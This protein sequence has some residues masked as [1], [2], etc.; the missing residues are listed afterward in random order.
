MDGIS[1]AVPKGLAREEGSRALVDQ[2]FLGR[3]CRQDERAPAR[4]LPFVALVPY[5]DKPK[6][7]ASVMI[8]KNR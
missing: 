2:R 1:A 8:K 6:R 3:R 5:T 7:E 4:E